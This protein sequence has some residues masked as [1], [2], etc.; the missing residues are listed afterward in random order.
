MYD[1]LDTLRDLAS[2][3]G[4][5][6]SDTFGRAEV[7]GMS[8]EE[9]LAVM[10]AAG[11]VLRSAQALIAETAG[12]VEHRSDSPERSERLT[13]RYG[14]RNT[15]ELVERITRMSGRSAVECVRAGRA[16]A[17]SWS[18]I[19][20]EMLPAAYPAM[21]AALADG[22]V[23]VDGVVA[24]T[25]VLDEATT[26]RE[27]RDAAET[28]LAASARGDGAD[29]SGIPTADDLRSQAQ[30]WAAYLDPDG[31]EPREKVAERQRGFTI[32][33]LRN[34]LYPV[35]GNL[36]PETAGMIQ[37]AFDAILNPTPPGMTGRCSWTPSTPNK[38]RPTTPAPRPRNATTRSGPS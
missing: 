23:G 2:Q 32:G 33:R 13:T 34:G 17:V 19:S 6:V 1:T 16:T 29:G 30:V 27:H 15:R 12:E 31:A 8:D 36:L 26:T 9:L 37:R 11:S 22:A 38:A 14:C 5:V 18:L 28:E 20:G 25:G 4:V 21:R 7:R 24:V 3:L 10:D 35:S